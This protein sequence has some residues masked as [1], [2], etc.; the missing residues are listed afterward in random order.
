MEPDAKKFDFKSL[1]KKEQKIANIIC[2]CTKLG[3]SR[4]EQKCQTKAACEEAKKEG[5]S[6]EEID[7]IVLKKTAGDPQRIHELAV[8][9][10]DNSRV[11][12]DQHKF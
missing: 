11:Q 4:Y 7:A 10:T 3:E 12:M 2:D 6:A 5:C 1:P 8:Y 9:G